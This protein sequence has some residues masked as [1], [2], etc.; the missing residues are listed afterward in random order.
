[1]HSK[2]WVR[3]P[4]VAALALTFAANA[5]ADENNGKKK[6]RPH[7]VVPTG[8]EDAAPPP[9]TD[10]AAEAELERITSRSG[11]GLVE[12]LNADGTVSVDLEGRFQHVLVRTEN[13]DGT[14]SYGCST[15]PGEKVALPVA[16][17]SRPIGVEPAR[18]A[19][20]VQL[21]VHAPRTPAL[22]EK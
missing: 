4:L 21:P 7:Q 22:E 10:T 16:L 12:V 2:L 19:P 1:M 8:A 17:P 15:H 3:A 13:A 9:A 18:A 20:T 14:A 5:H 11:E 6:G